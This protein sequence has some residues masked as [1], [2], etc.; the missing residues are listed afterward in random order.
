MLKDKQQRV[1]KLLWDKVRDGKRQDAL[2][3]S[4]PIVLLFADFVRVLRMLC[5]MATISSSATFSLTKNIDVYM[6]AFI[7]CKILPLHKFYNFRIDYVCDV[8]LICLL[9]CLHK[10][11]DTT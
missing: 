1:V 9:G 5:S 10:I 3:S 2:I 11:S 8:K 7:K 4:V 6:S